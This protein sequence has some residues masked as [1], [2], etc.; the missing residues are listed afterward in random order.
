MA[1][2]DAL[3]RREP[4]RAFVGLGANLGE[5][6]G[7]LEAALRSLATLPATTLARRSSAYRSAPIDAGGPDYVN[8]VA[9]LSTQLAPLDL[10]GHLQDIE[11]LHGRE[12]SYR[13]AP[14][15]LDLDLLLYGEA[16]IETPALSV[17]HPR[18]HAR[19]FVLAPL[20]ELW[21]EG[22]IPGR[23]RIAALLGA[24]A[25]QRIERL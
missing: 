17:P 12:R 22:A 13:N 25:D 23:G 19:A 24:V 5:T 16:T 14:R 15:T 1:A 2:N 3:P 21:P 9:E 4:V 10:L 6:R 7:T 18:M 20:A 8:A 11:R